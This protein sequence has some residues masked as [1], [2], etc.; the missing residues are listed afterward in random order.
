MLSF[1][2]ILLICLAMAQIRG[3][4]TKAIVDVF[5]EGSFGSCSAWEGGKWLTFGKGLSWGRGVGENFT[6]YLKNKLQ[7]IFKDFPYTLRVPSTDCFDSIAPYK[8][9]MFLNMSARI[10]LRI[11]FLMQGN[12]WKII[13]VYNISKNATLPQVFVKSI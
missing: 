9:C 1:A 3:K 4:N 8:N 12:L 13:V 6:G 7:Q 10:L 2:W 11:S 5:R